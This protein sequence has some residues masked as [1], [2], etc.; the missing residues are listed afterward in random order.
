MA[1]EAPSPENHV[2]Q[3]YHDR[4]LRGPRHAIVAQRLIL[5]SL[6]S[7][8]SQLSVPVRCERGVR[9]SPCHPQAWRLLRAHILI[10][11]VYKERLLGSLFQGWFH[12]SLRVIVRVL[13]LQSSTGAP[14]HAHPHKLI[15]ADYSS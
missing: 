14:V 15:D 10:R 5:R 6:R 9:L 4:P 7:I 11:P 8:P 2:Y 3:C 12:C 13:V 1:A